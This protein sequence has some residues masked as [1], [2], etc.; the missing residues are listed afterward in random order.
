LS[1][2]VSTP[3]SQTLLERLAALGAR[4]FRHRLYLGLAA[5]PIGALIIRPR[6]LF[7]YPLAGTLG[8]M[9]LVLL[10]L[11]LRAWAAGSAGGH[12]RT[13]T[14]EAPRLATG[15]PYAYVRNPIYLATV[16]LGCG[17]VGLLGDPR[18]FVLC[19]AALAFLYTSMVPAEERFLRS[20]FGAV[21]ERYCADV[22]R[23]IPRW[24]PWPQATRMPFDW[25][26]ARG[27]AHIA[28]ICAAIYVGLRLVA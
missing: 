24:Q 4:V 13:A 11:S 3:I 8:A 16:V 22:P 23:L 5:V 7:A 19:A 6:P 1:A 17:M 27:E 18:L 15:G 2:S 10:G 28:L 9:L 12:T 20:E 25:R 14:I 21:Y 26:A